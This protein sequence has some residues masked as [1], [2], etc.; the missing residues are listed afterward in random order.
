MSARSVVLGTVAL[1]IV[2]IV[3]AGCQTA[4]GPLAPRA[5]DRP[6]EMKSDQRMRDLYLSVIEQL[7]QY[8]KFHAALAHIDE[9]ERLY[10]TT[11]RSRGLRADA[12]LALGELA[13]AEKE[14]GAIVRGPLAGVG[15]HG[16]GS[17]AAARGDWPHAVTYFEQAVHEQ[18]TNT[19]FLTDLGRAYSE[20]G[21][22]DDAEFALRKAQELS[23]RANQ[24]TSRLLTSLKESGQPV[25]VEAINPELSMS[26]SRPGDET[27]IV[28]ESA[29]DSDGAE[30]A[31]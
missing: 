5:T 21:R 6:A 19:F 10:G 8:E 7:E 3:T 2:S 11:S 20:V 24:D 17:I 25:A 29:S 23:P 30:P 27:P 4:G 26:V 16:L 14:Y 1:G 28:V 13:S 9:F 18:P 15:R 22:A 12:W 31:Q